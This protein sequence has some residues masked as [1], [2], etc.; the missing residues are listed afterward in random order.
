M[1]ETKTT[2]KPTLKAIEAAAEKLKG[3]ASVTPLTKNARYS[4]QFE[5]KYLF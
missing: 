2:Y 3:I 1:E 5:C 4:K